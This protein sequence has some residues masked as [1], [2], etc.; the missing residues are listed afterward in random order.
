MKKDELIVL[1]KSALGLDTK[2]EAE[3]FINEVDAIIEALAEGLNVGDKV[4][5]GQHIS[6]EKVEVKEITRSSFGK[7]TV[8]PAHETLK[9]KLTKTGKELT[10]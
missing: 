2:K 7:Q 8:T 9:I 5:L 6:V 4:K 3:G 10:K 1:T